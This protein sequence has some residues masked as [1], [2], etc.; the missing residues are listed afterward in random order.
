MTK[1]TMKRDNG[2]FR[3]STFIPGCIILGFIS[4]FCFAIWGLGDHGH[5][6]WH[7]VACKIEKSSVERKTLDWF[8]LTVE[9]SLPENSRHE[10]QE[11]RFERLGE[12][13]PLLEKYAPGTVHP[14]KVD[15]R[16]AAATYLRICPPFID[17]ERL[18]HSIG[19]VLFGSIVSVFCLIGL[20]LIASSFGFVRRLLTKRV[21]ECGMAMFFMVFG[22]PFATIG[23]WSIIEAPKKADAEKEYIPTTAKV[24]YSG[25]VCHS[26]DRGGTAY[27][28]RI[29]YEYSVDGKIYESDRFESSDVY[30][31]NRKRHDKTV[32]AYKPG[33]TIEV[34]VSPENPRKVV[35]KRSASSGSFAIGLASVFAIIGWGIIVAALVALFIALRKRRTEFSGHVLHRS[36]AGVIS[37]GVFAFLWNTISWPLALASFKDGVTGGVML[38]VAL[39]PTVGIWFLVMFAYHFVREIRAPRLSLVLDM[40][41]GANAHVAWSIAETTD[42]ET[43]K[44]ALDGYRIVGSGKYSRKETVFRKDLSCHVAPSVPSAG[45]FDFAIASED[46][47]GDDVKWRITAKVKTT[48]DKKPFELEYNLPV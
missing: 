32:E 18:P 30:T 7:E 26:G 48:K 12:R 47:Y 10:V 35:I 8:V 37:I 29:G 46:D 31:G 42:I 36:R 5:E 2:S 28:P 40:P 34:F 1:K 9:Y 20:C 24:L 39:F 27:A 14:C 23:T 45:F 15:P 21:R 44:F 38:L 16:N 43:I 33:D 13:L 17:A 4:F 22:L 19:N 6:N 11:Y 3:L 25:V 41:E